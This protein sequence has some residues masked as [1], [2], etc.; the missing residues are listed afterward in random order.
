M[1]KGVAH[2][3]KPHHFRMTWSAP[4]LL[5]P[6]LVHL[7]WERQQAA[8]SALSA[9][10]HADAYEI[11]F[12]VSGSVDWWARQR[13]YEVG[14]GDVYLTHPDEPH[15][16]VDAVMHPSELYWMILPRQQLERLPGVEPSVAQLLAR[17]LDAI[18]QHCFFGGAA[19]ERGFTRLVQLHRDR[20]RHAAL[21]ARAALH[22]LLGEVVLAYRSR[23]EQTYSPTIRAALQWI[24]AHVLED[25]RMNELAH[26]V[27]LTVNHFQNRFRQEVGLPPAEYRQ[28]RRV[29]LAK[30]M[31]RESDASVTQI[32]MKLGFSSSQYF[33]TVF[34]K[35]VGMTPSAYR[36]AG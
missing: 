18:R 6:E 16:G 25:Y 24:D 20:P 4:A 11:C 23:R 13:V 30:Q 31:L 21:L 14:A 5:T 10:V 32:A 9:H 28:R 7:G 2:L 22:E 36:G 33:A 19:V 27:G 35:L 1:P 26:A 29:R 3:V 8:R 12:I 17:D 34:A 15:G